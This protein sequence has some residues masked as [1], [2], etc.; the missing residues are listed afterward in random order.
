MPCWGVFVPADFG[1]CLGYDTA[2][3]GYDTAG[4]GHVLGRPARS[5]VRIEYYY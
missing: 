4:L 1:R 5:R 2:G 3:L